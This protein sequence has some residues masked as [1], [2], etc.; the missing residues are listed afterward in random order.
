MAQFIG[1]G[2]D[3]FIMFKKIQTVFR[4]LGATMVLDMSAF[5]A[6]SLELAYIEFKERYVNIN[7]ERIQTYLGAT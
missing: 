3:D 7:S 5:T 2:C 6:I 4:Q 1:E